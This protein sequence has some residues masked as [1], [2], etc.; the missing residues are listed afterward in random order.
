MVIARTL[1]DYG[2]YIVDSGGCNFQLFAEPKAQ[3]EVAQI[4]AESSWQSYCSLR[5]SVSLLRIVTNNGPQSVGGGGKPR[6]PLAPAFCPPTAAKTGCV[7]GSLTAPGTGG[8]RGEH[9]VCYAGLLGMAG[10]QKPSLSGSDAMKAIVRY[11]NVLV[12]RLDPSNGSK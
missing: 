4:K 8:N 6:A 2:A 3:N 9:R 5:K 7:A 1:Q 11:H 10:R 12:K